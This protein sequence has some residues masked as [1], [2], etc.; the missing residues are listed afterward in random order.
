MSIRWFYAL[1]SRPS[2]LATVLTLLTSCRLVNFLYYISPIVLCINTVRSI[3]E[4]TGTGRSRCM[5]CLHG[6]VRWRVSYWSG[7]SLVSMG[8]HAKSGRTARQSLVHCGTDF[9]AF[10]TLPRLHVSSLPCYH[11]RPSIHQRAQPRVDPL[12][13]IPNT[14]A[15]KKY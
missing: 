1:G 4:R 3:R 2:Y 6:R 10:N 8:L 14:C 5:F 9:S 12:V 15:V 13:A 11:R 7:I